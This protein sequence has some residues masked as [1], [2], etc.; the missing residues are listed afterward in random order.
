MQS[1]TFLGLFI[2][3]LMVASIFGVTIDYFAQDT[4]SAN[5]NGHKITFRQGLYH[6]ALPDKTYTLNF[7]PQDLEY[8]ELTPEIRTLLD[9]PILTV[10]YDPS[11][12]FA[13]AGANAQYYLESQL[14]GKKAIVRAVTNN[15]GTTLPQKTC[16]DATP[17]EPIL[18]LTS[19]DASGF[20]LENNCITVTAIDPSDL[21]SQ[22]ERVIYHLLGVIP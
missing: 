22:T 8:I 14:E 15:T 21:F 17:S 13:E 18:F 1:K 5:Y 9:G 7:H 4:Q 3:F 12:G 19:S 2:A 16:A 6:L 10:T 20:T 11:S